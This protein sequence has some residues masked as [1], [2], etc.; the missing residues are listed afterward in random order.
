MQELDEV[1]LVARIKQK[2]QLQDW[3]GIDEVLVSVG[4]DVDLE[5]E[6]CPM[7]RWLLIRTFGVQRIHIVVA[8]GYVA[9]P[10]AELLTFVTA[11]EWGLRNGKN[12]PPWA[13]LV[14]AEQVFPPVLNMVLFGLKALGFAIAAPFWAALSRY[15]EPRKVMALCLMLQVPVL[16]TLWPFYPNLEMALFLVFIQ[17]ILA[18]GSFLFLVFNFMM[19]IKADMTHYAVRLGALEMLRYV[20]NWLSTGYIF[21]A[22][23]TSLHGTKAAPLTIDFTFLLLPVGLLMIL[24]TTGPAVL[25][26]F[27]PGPYRNDRLPGWNLE[28]FHC[29]KSFILFLL[30]DCFGSLALFPANCYISWWISNGWSSQ[31]LSGLSVFFAFWLAAG[32]FLWTITL[33]YTSVHSYSFLIGVALM[34]A[35]PTL[36]R[37]LVQEEVATITSTEPSQAALLVSV[38]TLFLEGVRSS[39]MWTTKIRILNSRWR[40][41]SYG[42]ILQS[43]SHFCAFLSPIVCELLARQY[44]VTFKTWNQKEL[45]DAILASAL[46][47]SLLQFFFQV[48]A[49]GFIKK[50]MGISVGAERRTKSLL[51]RLRNGT[52]MLAFG[53]FLASSVVLISLSFFF[54]KVEIN[55]ISRCVRP[56]LVNCT[57]MFEEVDRQAAVRG[58]HFGPNQFG[59]NTTG[60]YNCLQRMHAVRGD[61]FLFWEFGQCQVYWCGSKKALETGKSGGES[62]GGT[63]DLWSQYC[64]MSRPDLIVA[65][66]FE[67]PWKDVGDECGSHLGPS[68]FTAVQVSPPTEHVLGDTWSSRYQPVSFKLDSRNG[69]ASEFLTMVKRCR[70]AGISVMVDVVINHMAGPFVNVPEKDR[71]KECGRPHDTERESTVKCVGWAG[72]EYGNRMFMNGRRGR[73]QFDRSMFHHYP[74]ND[75]DNCGLPPWTGNKR[76]CDMV[77]LPDLN[78]ELKAVQLQLG[79]YLFELLEMGV[80]MLRVDAAM[81]IYPESLA[82][83]LFPF[84][85]EHIVQEYYPD[86]LENLPVRG[87]VLAVGSATDFTFGLRVAQTVFDVDMITG[88]WTGK[89]TNRS[90][91][92]GELLQM[93][94]DSSFKGCAQIYN[95]CGS[96]YPPER[97]LIFLDNHD[98]QRERWKGGGPGHAVCSWDGR[99][100]GTCRPI[101]KHGEIYRIAQLYMLVWPYGQPRP[102]VR[103]MSSYVFNTFDD[104]PPGVGKDSLRDSVTSPVVCRD[105]PTESPVRDAYDQDDSKPWVCEHR[106]KGVSGAIR[107]RQFTSSE[108]AHSMWDDGVGHIAFSVGKVGFAAFSR[109]YNWYTGQGSNASISLAGRNASLPKGCYCNLANEAGV[110]PDP[111]RWT[112]RCTGEV[113]VIGQSSVVN[114]T[115]VSG[116]AVIIHSLYPSSGACSMLQWLINEFECVALR[117]CTKIASFEFQPRSIKPWKRMSCFRGDKEEQNGQFWSHQEPQEPS[118]AWR[119]LHRLHSRLWLIWTLCSDRILARRQG[120][121]DQSRHDFGYFWTIDSIVTVCWLYSLWYLYIYVSMFFW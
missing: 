14:L 101:Y 112:G 68:G 54:L 111:S 119:P 28:M 85:W 3:S 75:R 91:H 118:N 18:S 93:Q 21:L 17:G 26:L 12:V 97:A 116:G 19:S 58:R 43:C 99:E 87:K 1:E 39:A 79:T 108:Q 42:A 63:F 53:T 40:L 106:W 95:L 81:H 74:D 73:D 20:V 103:I 10:V 89:W 11:T 52:S 70:A 6:S 76:L 8:L 110:V 33:S 109:G 67:W 36:L 64:D 72:T 25:L 82:E 100:I 78:T 66:L 104:G 114:A 38:L 46:P 90:Q 37:Y 62:P 9:S 45:A 41:L 117:L 80:T 61:T 51:H 105:T 7:S 96:L 35:P 88:K 57:V 4:E 2:T 102:S 49:A 115:L 120:L 32:T 83:I 47:F 92:F 31:E 107:F 16:I 27:A 24:L 44:G 15:M 30:S 50:D 23:P 84:P 29:K 34:L 98:S 60:L 77:G 121:K 65:H 13:Q 71:G 94:V 55:K 56:H 69:N 86:V 22:S 5:R 48:L 113:V 59:E